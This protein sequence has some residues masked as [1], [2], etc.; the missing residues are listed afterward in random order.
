MNVK[1]LIRIMPG[2]ISVTGTQ[3]ADVNSVADDS[4][5]VKKGA[6]FVAVSGDTHDGHDFIADALSQGA[7]GV[8][9][10]K[11]MDLGGKTYIRVKDSRKALAWS[12][13]WFYGYPSDKLN[14]RDYGNQRKTTIT[15]SWAM[16]E[17]WCSFS[18]IDT[19]K[20]N[21]RRTPASIPTD[22]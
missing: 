21:K 5:K 18:L 17:S 15:S 8:I 10:E 20:C 22:L 2:I 9:G 11:T 16:L 7:E 12:S 14:N 13:A 19:W 3:E 4:R 6:L 1:E